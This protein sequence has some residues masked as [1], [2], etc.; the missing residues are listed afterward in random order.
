MYRIWTALVIY[1]AATLVLE[2]IFAAKSSE[3]LVLD[4]II[5]TS[6]LAIL[7]SLLIILFKIGIK[8][9]VRKTGLENDLRGEKPSETND[10]TKGQKTNALTLSILSFIL[11]LLGYFSMGISAVCGFIIGIIAILRI[12]HSK[13]K[14]AACILAILGITVSIACVAFIKF[15]LLSVPYNRDIAAREICRKNLVE[16]YKAMRIYSNEY[17]GKYPTADNWCDLLIAHAGAN[18]YSFCCRRAAEIEKQYRYTINPKAEPNSSPSMVFLYTDPNGRRY[19]VKWGYYA[20]NPY[21]Q[22]D[23]PSNLV[24]LFETKGGWNKCG[25]YELVTFENHFIK[26]CNVLFNDGHV[27]FVKPEQVDRLKWK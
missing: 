22:P 16:L 19:C 14:A 11:S 13:R 4:V 26:G 10:D 24:L 17:E 6:I 20:I 18:N 25:G 15:V 1:Y 8:G 5:L 27:E 3:G 7:S 21:V 12:E 2:D 23:S 9:V